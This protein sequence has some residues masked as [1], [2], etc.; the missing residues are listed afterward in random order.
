VIPFDFASFTTS[1]QLLTL[2]KSHAG[3]FSSLSHSLSMAARAAGIFIAFGRGIG[4]CTMA[5]KKL[6]AVLDSPIL[7]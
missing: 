5:K 3:T 7:S 4:L 2:F 1:F 6:L